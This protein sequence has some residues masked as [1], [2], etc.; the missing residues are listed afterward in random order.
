LW[1]CEVREKKILGWKNVGIKKLTQK[2]SVGWK[3]FEI[4]HFL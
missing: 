4:L 1:I 2:T 3:K